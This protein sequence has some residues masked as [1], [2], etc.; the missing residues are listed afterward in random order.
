MLY[1]Q[2]NELCCC[3]FALTLTTIPIYPPKPLPF[4][5]TH[6]SPYHPYLPIQALT[7]PIYP[8]KP[9]PFLSTHPSPYH[10]YLPTQALTIPVYP[11]KP[12]PRCYY[13]CRLDTTY[14]YLCT[15]L[16]DSLCQWTYYLPVFMYIIT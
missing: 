6:P 13:T 4:L 11:P 2:D 16:H 8:P 10:S 9:L 15:S 14:L 1:I 3:L 7:I 5:S 12:L